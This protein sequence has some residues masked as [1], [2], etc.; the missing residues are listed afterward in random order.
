MYSY[1]ISVTDLPSQYGDTSELFWGARALRSVDGQLI[2]QFMKHLLKLNCDASSCS[3]IKLPLEL[4]KAVKYAVVMSL[5]P[6]YVCEP[7]N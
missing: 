3:W 4:K 2:V 1:S 7:N 5:P 6:T